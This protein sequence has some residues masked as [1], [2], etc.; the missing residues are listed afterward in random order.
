MEIKIMKNILD[1]NQNKANEVRNLLASRKVLMV[2]IISSPGAG[3]T[4]LLERTCEA[5]AS[6]FRIGVIEGDV[7]TDRDAQRL[8]KYNI[9]IVVIN[10]EGGCHLDSHSIS[11]VLDS[12]D[13]DNLDVLFV[14]NVGNLICPSQFDLGETFKLAVVS[15]AEGDDKPDKYPMLFREAKAVLLN[16][17][18]LIQYTNFNH[19]NFTRDLK[20]ING[21]ILQF[22]VSCTRGDGLEEWFKWITDQISHLTSEPEAYF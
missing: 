19:E 11:K 9:P 12:F 4:T 5:L 22:D 6:K 16:K 15:T 18:D 7:T 14:E 3:K 2:N 17:I 10:T 1:R 8:K 20:K 21:K 13:L